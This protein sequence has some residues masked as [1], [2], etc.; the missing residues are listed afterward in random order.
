MDY[1][2]LILTH[3]PL[4]SQKWGKKGACG[5]SK[6][7]DFTGGTLLKYG[8]TAKHTHKLRWFNLTG[9][10]FEQDFKGGTKTAT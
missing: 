5:S 9:W 8:V 1:L 4:N 3:E 2:G 7:N 6:N 10:D